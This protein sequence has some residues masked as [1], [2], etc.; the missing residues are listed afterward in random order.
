MSQGQPHFLKEPEA[1]RLLEPYGIAY[2]ANMFANSADLAAS[3]ASCLG[4]PVVL[5]A[6]SA[7][8]VHK[9]E[10]G[11]VQRSLQDQASVRA[12]FERIAQNLADHDPCA[13]LDGVL[14]VRQVPEG[15]DL[16]VGGKSD[17]SFGPVVMMGLG[18]TLVEIIQDVSIR[19]A[20]LTR[21]EADNMI[22][23]TQAARFIAGFRGAQRLDREA[24]AQL[25]MRVGGFLSDHPG[26][27]EFDLNPVRLFPSGL[28]T[29][30]VRVAVPQ[31]QRPWQRPLQF[32][33]Q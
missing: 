15:L 2:P 14:V 33:R 31:P 29:L 11:G 25:L 7:S 12:A 30:D 6:V 10:A 22:S 9:S 16:I 4:F 24:L 27:L 17:P 21:R 18:G 19:L 1:I 13:C 5:K 28:S 26:V 20:P 23:E 32:R 3:A 8:L